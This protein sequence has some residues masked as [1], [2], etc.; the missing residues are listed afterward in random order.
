MGLHDFAG[1][2]YSSVMVYVTPLTNLNLSRRE[3]S[4]VTHTIHILFIPRVVE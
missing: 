1:V 2:V 4:T 3:Y